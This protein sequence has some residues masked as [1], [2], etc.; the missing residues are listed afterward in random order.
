V[1]LISLG[2]FWYNDSQVLRRISSLPPSV[3][4]LS[5]SNDNSSVFFYMVTQQDDRLELG[6][7][8]VYLVLTHMLPARY[9]CSL[10]IFLFESGPLNESN[11]EDRLFLNSIQPLVPI[12][13]HSVTF[14]EL[15][16]RT[17]VTMPLKIPPSGG[18]T[19]HREIELAR[20]FIPLLFVSDWYLY[21]DDDL[22]QRRGEFFP[23]VM[24]FTRDASKIMFAVQDHWF[25]ITKD[26]QQRVQRY[27]P[28]FP[29]LWYYGSGF[30]LMR[31]GAQLNH[32]L[33]QTLAYVNDHLDLLYIDQD[34]LNLGFNFSYVYFLPNYFSVLS[35]QHQQLWDVG[36][37]FHYNGFRKSSHFGFGLP[38]ATT[39]RNA[40]QEWSRRSRN[41]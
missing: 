33:R 13:F 23:K 2:V 5:V 22:I 20:L 7:A 29:G 14:G 31:G 39:Y 11:E 24:S 30:L 9:L 34:G 27:H 41:G 35:S 38:L 8:A 3:E 10:H 15:I 26:F 32:E 25:C 36:Y 19:H 40:K 18:S 17:E 6:L 16:N 21:F 12:C 28:Q 4:I 37:A 1:V